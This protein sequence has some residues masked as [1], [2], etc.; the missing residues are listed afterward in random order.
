[1]GRRDLPPNTYCRRGYYT[2]RN[3]NTR[4]EFGLGRD[5]HRACIEAMEANVRIA[6]LDRRPR[7]IDRISGDAD[8]S[9][10]AWGKKYSEALSKQPLA[11]NTRRTYA[12]HGRRVVALLGA[13]TAVR[14]VTAMQV[15]EALERVAVV[16][17]KARLAQAVRHFM[18]DWFRE[19]VVQGWRDDNPVRDTKLSVKVEVKRARLAYDVFIGIYERTACTWLRNAMAL[20]LVSAQRRE[21]IAMAQFSAFHNGGWWL[22][23]RSEKATTPHRI[24]IPLELRL[25]VFGMSLADVVAQCRR[26]G[27]VSRY[28]VHQTEPR[29]NSPVGSRM[30]LDTI[31]KRFSDEVELITI[32]HEID[33]GEK[34]PPTFHEIRSLSERLYADQGGVVT[35]HLLGHNDAETTAVYHDSR[36]SEWVHA[37]DGR[38]LVSE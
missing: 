38:K 17:G 12:S 27:C 29:G 1:M 30:W 31:S 11:D 26:T 24:F 34:T 23:Q 21:D 25:D 8:R 10:A 22:I 2:W 16:E 7:L 28:L 5:K 14:S 32:E 3:P 36:G 20:A 19:A 13:S 6:N 37:L 33:W 9:V 18:R 4:E 15:S 35:Q